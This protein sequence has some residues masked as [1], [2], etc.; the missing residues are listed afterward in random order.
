MSVVR[1]RKTERDRKTET[2][3]DGTVPPGINLDTVTLKKSYRLIY[4]TH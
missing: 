3:K 2:G 4:I 1:E